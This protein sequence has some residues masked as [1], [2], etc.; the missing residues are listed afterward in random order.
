ML[1]IGFGFDKFRR[2]NLNF[3]ALNN[4][5]GERRLNVLITRARE[6]CVVFSNFHA[7]DLPL[8]A[9]ASFGLR[10]LKVFLDF[11]E[12]RNLHSIEATGE[13]TDSPF[14]DA[15]YNFLRDYGYEVH[16]QIGCAGYKVDLA[17]VDSESPGCYLLG[18]E[19]DGAKYHSSPVARERDRLRQQIL[20]NLGWKIYR[21][22][23]TDWYRNRTESERK[24]PDAVEKVNR[25][26]LL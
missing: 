21:V 25:Y 26:C 16:K 1:S 23:S 22:W 7:R 10:A 15:V 13:D 17:I 2:L 19:C 14:E 12:N 4:E 8:N 6:Q 3:G 20:E 11:A 24:L 9:N 18:I 5:G